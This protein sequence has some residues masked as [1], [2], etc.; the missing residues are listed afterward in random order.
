MNILL[1][2]ITQTVQHI[3]AYPLLPKSGVTVASLLLL[4]FL[5]IGVIVAERIFRRQ[6]LTRALRRTHLAPVLNWGDSRAGTAPEG[7]S[8]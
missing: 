6:F 2:D 7:S 3:L 5:L 1:K 4:I 8:E